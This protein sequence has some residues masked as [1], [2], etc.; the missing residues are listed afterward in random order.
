[1]INLHPRNTGFEWQDHSGPF[2]MI[3][4]AQ[5]KQFDELGYFLLPEVFEPHLLDQ[6]AQE[7]EPLEAQ[8]EAFLQTRE[9]GRYLIARAG[10]ITFTAHLVTRS[11]HLKAFSK[12]SAFQKLCADLIG[13]N[14]RLYWD[15]AVYKK[16]GTEEEFPWHQDNGYTF[17]DPQFYLTCWVPLVDATLENGCPWV[18]PHLHRRGTLAHEMTDL[19][20]QCLHN[21]QDAVPVEAKAGDVVVLSSLT[22]HRTGPNLSNSIRKAYILQ[23]APDGVR[24]FDPESGAWH[25]ANDPHRQYLI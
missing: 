25:L 22:P 20:W 1:M 8:T 15:Q 14:A 11:E 6:L 9:D 7:I 16:P 24:R 2:E 3:T 5:A 12:H 23:Y 13:A 21:P 4:D 10:E 18:V 17:I 19:G